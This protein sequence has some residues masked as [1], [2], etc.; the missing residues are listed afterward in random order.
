MVACYL[1]LFNDNSLKLLAQ[2]NI[3]DIHFS[4]ILAASLR[5]KAFSHDFTSAILVFQNNETAA[6][7]VFQTSR[8]FVPI[9]FHGCWSL[10]Q[11][12]SI[13]A[14]ESC[15]IYYITIN[16]NKEGKSTLV[17]ARHLH[18]TNQRY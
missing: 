7:L 15:Y 18:T 6:M 13:K 5:N 2:S 10:E 17:R 1:C 8:S 3:V 11:K 4:T 9:S 12:R 16:E 14:G